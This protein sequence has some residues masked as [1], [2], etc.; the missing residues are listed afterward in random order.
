MRVA[1]FALLFLSLF[2]SGCVRTTH[3]I[4]TEDQVISNNALLGKWVSTDGKTSAEL[5]AGDEGKYKLIYTNE[6]GKSGH[7]LLRFGKIGDLAVAEI[8]P[9]AF[10]ADVSEEYKG[11]LMPLYMML[12]IEKTQPQLLVASPSADWLKKYVTAH[13]DD[14]DVN[15]VEDLIVQASTED[16]QAFFLKHYKDAG[17][18]GDPASFVRPAPAK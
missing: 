6:Q 4:L 1:L 18:L 2:A 11:L 13:P 3:P 16:F 9:D 17:M 12:V 8:S 15:N 5:S 10:S 14:L 7:F